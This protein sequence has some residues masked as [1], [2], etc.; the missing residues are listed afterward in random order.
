[1]IVDGDDELIGK[2]VLK[3]FNIAYQKKKA[4]FIYSNFYTYDHGND[5]VT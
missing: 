1:M 2:N 3:L 4:G 5:E